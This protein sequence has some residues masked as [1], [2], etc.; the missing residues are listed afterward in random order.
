M[1]LPRLVTVHICYTKLGLVIQEFV[2]E[3]VALFHFP[4][5]SISSVNSSLLT[6]NNFFASGIDTDNNMWNIYSVKD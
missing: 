3:R 1:L 2:F 6:K 4:P 5:V